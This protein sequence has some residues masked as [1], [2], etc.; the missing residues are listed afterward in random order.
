MTSFCYSE[1][2]EMLDS[3]LLQYYS[4]TV[5]GAVAGACALFPPCPMDYG[6]F[7]NGLTGLSLVVGGQIA[8]LACPGL[9]STTVH[10]KMSN[11]R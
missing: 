2:Y 10:Q 11:V 9:S 7:S 8:P 6:K 1:N 3:H 4:I 5:T